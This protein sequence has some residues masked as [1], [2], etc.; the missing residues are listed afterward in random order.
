MGLTD[1]SPL[2]LQAQW[3]LPWQVV[4]NPFLCTSLLCL[5]LCGQVVCG[6]GLFPSRAV[7]ISVL[8]VQVGGPALFLRNGDRKVAVTLAWGPSCDPFRDECF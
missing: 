5:C 4:T 2:C 7:R 8:M 6:V 1:L 3:Y